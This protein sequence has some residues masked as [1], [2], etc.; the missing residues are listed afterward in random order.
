MKTL[1]QKQIEREDVF[2]AFCAITMKL[3][4][5]AAFASLWI[6]HI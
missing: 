1:E 2:V 6:K 4:V 5:I 3:A